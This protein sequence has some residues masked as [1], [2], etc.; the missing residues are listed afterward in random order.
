MSTDIKDILNKANQELFINTHREL[1]KKESLHGLILIINGGKI[2]LYE[3]NKKINEIAE[4]RSE[5]FHRLK[6]ISHLYLSLYFLK[7]N[8]DINKREEIKKVIKYLLLNLN[9]LKLY[10]KHE[11]LTE[12]KSK[13][14]LNEIEIFLTQIDDFLE[15]KIKDF[16][17]LNSSVQN[18]LD[19]FI[20]L[21]AEVVEQDLHNNIQ[22]IKKDFEK[23]EKLE[24]WNKISVIVLGRL[25]H[26]NGDIT[27]QY[28]GR[29]TGKKHE[30]LSGYYETGWEPTSDDILRKKDRNLLFAENISETENA[31]L[32]LGEYRIAKKM[33]SDI[34]KNDI[35]MLYDLL[36]EKASKWLKDKC[37]NH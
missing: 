27:M 14:L 10:L 7:T 18:Y 4:Y 31:R 2:E 19:K 9:N 24:E 25:F 35:R 30:Q 22:N 23:R 3:D 16:D 8:D 32:L 11:I 6:E 13:I 34:F 36:A 15:Y 28:F 17:L 37:E 21:S 33:G 1:I 26:R 20:T 12:E 29:L 5:I